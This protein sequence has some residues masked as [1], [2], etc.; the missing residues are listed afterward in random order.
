MFHG[1]FSY[2]GLCT[3]RRLRIAKAIRQAWSPAL[4]T[5]DTKMVV[6]IMRSV[7]RVSLIFEGSEGYTNVRHVSAYFLPNDEVWA[8]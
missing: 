6:D 4:E 7:M 8:S 5:I 3:E 1:E 2:W